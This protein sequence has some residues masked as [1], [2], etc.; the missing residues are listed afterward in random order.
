MSTG[1]LV[2]GTCYET[3]SVAVDA[4]FSSVPVAWF[5][6]VNPLVHQVVK[7]EQVGGVWMRSVYGDAPWGSTLWSQTVAV[8]PVF[9][10]CYAPSESFA[11][12]V[13]AG[14]AFALCFSVVLLVAAARSLFKHA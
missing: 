5:Q 8:P 11:D 13:N 9:P 1:T 12:G 4:Y 7:Y 3:A 6:D 2:N 10:A 14:Y